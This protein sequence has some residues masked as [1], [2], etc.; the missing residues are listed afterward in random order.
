[1]V[2]NGRGGRR[3]SR[4]TF[5]AEYKLEVLQSVRDMKGKG[6][7]ALKAYL[8]ERDLRS[9]HLA[10]WNKQL[11]G[12]I[13]GEGKRG[14]PPK[15]REAL[16]HEVASLRRRL[17]AME[18]RALQAERLVMLQLKYVKG[19]AMK[20]E[21]RDRGLLSELISR[22][23]AETSVSSICEALS[24]TRKDFY[25]TIKPLARGINSAS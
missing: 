6:R 18:K 22:V 5:T 23:D 13:P 11:S 24:L 17:D 21:R 14:R 20:M 3:D 2:G 10:E 8:R 25:R 9:S 19:A 4:R 16:L 1:M 12:G 15:S 7:G